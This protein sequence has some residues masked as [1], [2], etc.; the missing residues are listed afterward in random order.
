[1]EHLRVQNLKVLLI[2]AKIKPKNLK[3][4]R[5]IAQDYLIN[6]LL[7]LKS[8]RK[9]SRCSVTKNKLSQTAVVGFLK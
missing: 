1:M 8:S 3:L 7:F 9:F 4:K 5:A 6:H 2:L